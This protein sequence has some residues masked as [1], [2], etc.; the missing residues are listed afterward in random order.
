MSYVTSPHF[1]NR[2]D[3]AQRLS[4]LLKGRMLYRPVVVGIPR[5]GVVLASVLAKELSAEMDVVLVRKIGAPDQPELAIGAVSE[6]E[7]VFLNPGSQSFD[8]RIRDYIA[9]ESSRQISVIRSRELLYRTVR[10]RVP[11]EGRSVIVTDDGIATGA[12]MIAAL[13][14]LKQETPREMIVAVPV[15]SPERLDEVR[16]WCDD[17][18]CLSAPSWFEAVG[19]FYEDFHPVDDD[20]VLSVLRDAAMSSSTFQT[21]P[22][23]N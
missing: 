2:E 6:N 17:V 19:Q 5:G 8:D 3:A 23:T 12:T 4:E 21:P 14:V 15:A 13:Q 16:R 9:D 20:D 10:P 22:D 7:R 11:I 1:R 18:V